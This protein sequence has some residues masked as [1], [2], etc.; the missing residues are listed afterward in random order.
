MKSQL[1]LYNHMRRAKE[2][3]AYNVDN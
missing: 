2:E 1:F 3:I